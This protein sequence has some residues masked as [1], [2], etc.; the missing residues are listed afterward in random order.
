MKHSLTRLRR[1][2]AA[3]LAIGGAMMVVAPVIA[4]TAAGV[5]I[6]NTATAT[7]NDPNDPS[8]VIDAT[9][10]TV[11]IEVAEVAGIFVEANGFT[12]N[13]SGPGNTTVQAGDDLTFE[14]VI[15][16]AGND[17]TFVD[18]PEANEISITNATIDATTPFTFDIDVDGDGTPEQTGVTKAVAESTALEPGGTI[19][20]SVNVTVDAGVS[21]GDTV[22]VQFGNTPGDGQN[23]PFDLGVGDVATNDT[24]D[25]SA[26]E[27][28]GTPINGEREAAASQSVPID[29]QALAF[30]SVFKTADL[31]VN[32][33]GTPTA[34]DDDIITYNLSLAVASALPTG[35][36]TTFAPADLVGTTGV[37]VDGD[38][39]AKILVSDA[40]PVGTRL[41]GVP[42]APAGWTV[43]YTTTA[44]TTDANA[45]TW[46][47]TPP[48]TQ[49]E[50][51][52]ITRVGFVSTSTV[53]Q[54]DT[55]N[56][57][58]QVETNGLNATTG[59][60]VNNIAQIF[61]K[62]SGGGTTLVY[63]ESGDQNPNNLNDDGTFGPSTPDANGDGIPEP[64]VDDGVADPGADGVD[65][66]NDNT[67]TG[68]PGGEDNVVTVGPEGDLLNGPDGTPGAT[69]PTDNND[70]FTNQSAD[71]PPGTAPGDTL[72]PD[73]VTFTNTVEANNGDLTG[74]G[75]VPDDG[76]ATATVP[77]GTIVTITVLDATGNPTGQ[78]DVYEYNGTDF[79]HLPG[80]DPDGTVNISTDITNGSTVDYTTEVDLP[81]G[82]PL[83]TDEPAA[84]PDGFPVPVVASDGTASN[85]TIDRVYTG[86][87]KLLKEAR[88]VDADGTTELFP[89]TDL[90]TFSPGPDQFIEYRIT[91]TNISSSGGVGSSLLNADNVVITEDGV[92]G[93]NTW[94][95]D[96]DTDGTL[97]TLHVP[98]FA[99]DAGPGGGTVTFFNGN[100]STTPS[101]DFDT[102]VTRY[103]DTLTNQLT[104]GQQGTFT[105]R[106]QLP[107]A[108]PAP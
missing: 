29:S 22:D 80:S 55:V 72:N 26:G 35:V 4:Q 24:P 20:A 5:N 6:S 21:A 17:T 28:A 79:V 27:V 70:D 78:V 1:S 95:L 43:V 13:T 49:T 107:P 96:Q 69:G 25:G 74:V 61:G 37:D 58:F 2:L 93:G 39:S 86:Y 68:S 3:T 82:T 100:P 14:F 60:D 87:L 75:L 30:A 42:T 92:A 19:T 65:T 67:A 44:T 73:P 18:L 76:A 7:Y 89:F 108:P 83:S 62:T 48:V 98:G 103:I 50:F 51:D 88:L 12:D 106:R 47:A 66:G 31:P 56:F 10:N 77:T 90:P 101:N 11:I 45:A 54:G 99:A 71:I 9:S 36:S 53:N 81:A 64:T 91:Y 8:T 104:P 40:I 63:D 46:T 94:G 84:F 32:D 34:F 41:T 33:S 52:A 97:D 15:T 23:Q 38:T 105:I 102:N 16:N 85:T 57:S 59:G